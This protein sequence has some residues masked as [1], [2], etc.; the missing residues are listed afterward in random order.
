MP[1]DDA[2]TSLDNAT[3]VNLI[4][5]LSSDDILAVLRAGGGATVSAAQFTVDDLKTMARAFRGSAVLRVV[6]SQ[7]IG[8]D[9]M[10]AIARAAQEPAHASFSGK[11]E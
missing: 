6:N 7:A 2:A 5:H 1:R 4:R 11:H 8:V 3:G 10:R 9:D